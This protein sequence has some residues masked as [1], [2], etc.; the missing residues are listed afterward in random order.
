MATFQDDPKE[1]FGDAPGE[2]DIDLPKLLKDAEQPKEGKPRTSKSEGKTG[3]QAA[4]ATEG[5]QA[6]PEETPPDPNPTNPQPSTS[7][8]PTEAPAEVPTGDP[9]QTTTQTPGKEE[10]AL[11]N[12]VKEYRAAG[13]AWLDTVVEKGEQA[14]DTLFEKLQQL[15][16]PHIP[17]FDQANKEQVFKCIRTGRFLSQDDFVLY[18]ETEEEQEKPKYKLTGDTKE[19]LRDYYDAVHT[20]CEAQQN[21]A[22][23]TQVLEEKIEDKSVFLDIIR[24]VQ[25]PAVQV[26]VRTVEELEKLEGKTYRECTLLCHLP[27]FRTIQPNATEQTRTISADIYFIL[28]GQIT[29]LKAS[30]TGCAT[31]FRSQMTPFK[32]LVTGKRQPGRPGRL[33]DVKGKSSRSLGEVAELEGGT[34]A[35]QRRMTR[36]STKPAP[37]VKPTGRGRGRDKGGRPKRT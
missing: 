32:R 28:Y 3:E 5:A 35:K 19:A 12:Y 26:Q 4:Q 22:R 37:Q 34:P 36:S 33:S 10:I 14:Y 7:K 27:N 1:Q 17:N 31:E 21:F 23:S 25:L 6:P 13:K 9:T 30:Q 29:G 16:D 11:T 2:E 8:D 18:V 20:L 15:G 24:Q